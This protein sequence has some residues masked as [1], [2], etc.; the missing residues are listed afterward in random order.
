MKRQALFTFWFILLFIPISLSQEPEIKWWFDLDDSSFGNAA[1]ADIDKDGFLE[2]VF[3]CYRND[4]HVYALNAENGTLLWK[5]D[6]SGLAEGCNDVAPIISDVDLDGNLEVIVPAS[7]NPKTFCF[8]G[9]TG[10][11]EWETSLHGSDSPPTIGDLDNDGKPEILHGNF[12]GT[13][14]C[15]NGEDGSLAWELTVD[16]NSWIQTAPVILD[17]DKDNQLDFVV[18]NWSFGTNH[19]IFC[20]KGDNQELIWE[21]DLPQGVMY[22]GASF[23]DI[24][25][26]EKMELAIGS[27]DGVLYVLNAEDGS[28]HWSFSFDN[29]NYIGA[30]TSIADLDGDDFYEILVFDGSKVAAIEH[31]GE[32]L[33]TQLIPY[34]GQS[35]RGAAISDINGDQMLDVI[36]GESNGYLKALEGNT[37][38]FIFNIDLGEHFGN[39]LFDIDHGPVIADFDLDGVLDIFIVGG[40]TEYPDFENNFGRAYAIS[41]GGMGGG[42]DWPM[43]RRDTARSA[44]VPIGPISSVNNSEDEISVNIMPN[45]SA[46]DVHITFQLKRPAQVQINI[47]DARGK[48]VSH[49]YNGQ[50]A[51]GN[52]HLI[53]NKKMQ[54]NPGFY[55]CQINFDN[56]SLSRKIVLMRK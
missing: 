56:I 31:T 12:G 2:I 14:S 13:V 48:L 16:A 51:P 46:G 22:H 45:P 10:T 20:F 47:F 39:N 32:I 4:G 54:A 28:L 11:I 26:D 5:Q 34:F 15:L 42:P 9:A 1:A 23:A 17:V 43:F 50:K 41:A 27:Y 8:D 18:A 38:D 21:S 19:K 36:F 7:C 40:F 44:H 25:G 3:G 33:W 49:L 53:W 55:I 6:L 37:G 24:D 29:P 30:P 52:H 35:F